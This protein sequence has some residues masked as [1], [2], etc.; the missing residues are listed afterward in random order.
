MSKN[1]YLDSNLGFQWTKFTAI[2][3][4]SYS[5]WW[6]AVCYYQCNGQ[7][8]AFPAEEVIQEGGDCGGK[9]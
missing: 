9:P 4:K 2:M 8:G 6:L 3:I 5:N 1:D 7:R